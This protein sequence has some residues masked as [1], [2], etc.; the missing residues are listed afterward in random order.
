MIVGY[1]T[2]LMQGAGMTLA[3]WFV[4]GSMSLLVGT[5]LGIISSLQFTTRF[6]SIVVKAYVFFAR[7]VPAYVQILIAY[8]ALPALTGY[9]M[10][11]FMA[12]TGALAFCSSGYIT[13]IVRAGINSISQGQWDAG[14]VLGYTPIMLLVRIIMPQA[15]TR[16][17]P[18]LTGEIEQLLKSTSLLATIGV[19]ELTRSGMNIISRELN[20]F[21]VYLTIACMYLCFSAALQ[22]AIYYLER[23]GNYGNYS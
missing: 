10:S 15:F 13:E 12:A 3:A 4:A 20:P 7:G 5:C 6:M 22:L 17:L 9:N 16:M 18:A 8:F 23:K 14:I 21:A 2:L 1:T 11:G 19:T